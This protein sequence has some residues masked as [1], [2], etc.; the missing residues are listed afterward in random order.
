MTLD[1]YNRRYSN[2]V[3]DAVRR[4]ITAELSPADAHNAIEMVLDCAERV[5]ME[6]DKTCSDEYW[7]RLCNGWEDLP[8]LL[9]KLTL[10]TCVKILVFIAQMG[11]GTIPSDLK[12]GAS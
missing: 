4:A 1:K 9:N 2:R 3:Y 8:T 10:D 11:A 7:K 5:A 6:D 12:Q